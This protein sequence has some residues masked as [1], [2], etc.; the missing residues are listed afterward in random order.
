MDRDETRT[1]LE[2]LAAA[3]PGLQVKGKAMPYLAVNGNMFA[4]ADPEG[5]LCL[6]FSEA[7]RAQL[8]AEFGTGPVE[9]Y[10]AVMRGYV[11]LPEAVIA[12]T[13]RLQALFAA[14]L[15]H[16]RQLKPKPTKR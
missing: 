1:V 14:C 5:A 13:A 10:G 4:F 3:V 7:E 8:A 12:D 15:D 9:Q 11:A 6:R 16:A 2:R